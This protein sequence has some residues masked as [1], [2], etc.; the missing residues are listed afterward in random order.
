MGNEV[1]GLGK[2]LKHAYETRVLS[3]SNAPAAVAFNDAWV[4][5]ISTTLQRGTAET[6]C[7]AIQGEKA[8]MSA[9]RIAKDQQVAEA[10]LSN[11]DPEWHQHASMS[12]CYN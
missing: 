8:L 2:D 10:A 1:K 5:R 3:I 6:L 9:A 11:K 12:A 4:Y 7:G